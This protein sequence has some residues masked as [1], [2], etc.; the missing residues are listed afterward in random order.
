ML[1]WSCGTTAQL[2]RTEQISGSRS[3]SPIQLDVILRTLATRTPITLWTV[4]K[5]PVTEIQ[6]PKQTL[7]YPK[8]PSKLA[9]CLF[10]C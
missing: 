3:S 10:V 8:D 2:D 9:I 6:V 4:T 5:H 1:R 7:H